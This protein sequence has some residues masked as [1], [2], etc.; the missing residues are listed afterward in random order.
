[1]VGKS[2]LILLIPTG[3]DPQHSANTVL[4]WDDKKLKSVG[5]IH[6]A[7]DAISVLFA[8]DLFMVAQK[9]SLKCLTM[10]DIKVMTS[11]PTYQNPK[12]L[13]AVSYGNE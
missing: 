3:D 11:I 10:K 7:N 9:D 6:F 12:G 2:N 4:L 13:Q 5:D 1:M 8:K